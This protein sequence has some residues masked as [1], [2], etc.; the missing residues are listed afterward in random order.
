[1]CVVAEAFHGRVFDR[2]VHPFDLAIGPWVR[3]LGCAMID[4]VGRT[5]EF[6]C[7]GSE[8]SAIGDRRSDQRHCR[9]AGTGS[10]DVGVIAC[11][12]RMDFVRHRSDQ[13]MQEVTGGG[14][15]GRLVQLDEGEL[16]RLV[17][18]HEHIKSALFA[19]HDEGGRTWARI[20]SVIETCKLNGVDPYSYLRDTLTAVAQG[21]PA[22][23]V[24]E[25]MPSA[26]P[27]KSS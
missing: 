1:M 2:S 19:G 27:K 13:A 22:S 16:A 25:L 15:L 24:D 4:I 23:R 7:V 20:A 3:W 12:N 26:F 14:S 21:H 11:E 18:W 8:Q 17:D 6:E 10:S 5:A 9:G